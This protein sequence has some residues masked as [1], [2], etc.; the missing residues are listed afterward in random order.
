MKPASVIAGAL[1]LTSA[2]A[3]CG[4]RAPSW[5]LPVEATSY[6]LNTGVAIVDEAAHRVLIVSANADLSTSEQS[7]TVGHNVVT[8][9]TSPDGNHLFVMS[10]GDWP[11][12]SPSD[13]P[14]SLTY[15]DATT[16]PVTV[17]PYPMKQPQPNLVLDPLGQY[18][19]AYTGPGTPAQFIDDPN[20]IV[21]FKLSPPATAPTSATLSIQSFGGTPQQLTFTPTLT[22]PDGTTTTGMQTRLLL[23][24]STIDLTILDMGH[25]FDPVPPQQITVQLTDGTTTQQE[26]P[27]GVA[28][29]D[30][31]PSNP[32]DA[33]IALWTST[34]SNVFIFQLGPSEPG[35]PNPFTPSINSA[36]VGAIPSTVAFVHTSAQPAN[37]YGLQVLALVPSQTKAVF[38]DEDDDT[39]EVTMP[40]PYTNL[41]VVTKIIDSP[42][43]GNGA[44][45][46]GPDTALLWAQS[47]STD[48]GVTGPIGMA[49]WDLG[50]VDGQISGVDV[51]SVSQP[52]QAVLDVGGPASVNPGL[53]IVQLATSGVYV[54]DLSS[55]MASPLDTNG[56]PSL[57]S[58][59][60]GTRLWAFA[61]NGT[62]LA[63]ISLPIPPEGLSALSV[64]PLITP[65]PIG[66]VYDVTIAGMPDGG[67][68]KPHALIATH[69][70]GTWGATVF[71]AE[72]PTTANAQNVTALL[73]EASP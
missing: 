40:T 31:D 25:A 10:N 65:M 16:T 2:A 34:D 11:P 29:D 62:D 32:N 20:E 37:D 1:A 44:S 26:T 48:D 53:K 69:P 72:N 64:V 28:V 33:R 13:Q 60:D 6:P 56:A 42:A 43:S 41:S 18:A 7:V 73:L 38:I 71:D 22:L 4:S 58:S 55:R 14:P 54:L 17:T 9:A 61:P 49:F 12:Q 39:T 50:E 15:I 59:A 30:G 70:Q 24:E 68:G 45:P 51:V 5:T 63:E 8:V 3:G 27:A 52:I 21:I 47:A 23:V 46:G 57:V 36:S 19:A 66:G 67:V 35:T